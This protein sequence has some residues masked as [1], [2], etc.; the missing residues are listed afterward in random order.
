[1]SNKRE[2]LKEVVYLHRTSFKN[3]DMYY[4]RVH[5]N[6][7]IERVEEEMGEEIEGML[8]NLEGEEI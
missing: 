7:F 6:D 8:A 2:L 3:D 1:M 5:F 4:F